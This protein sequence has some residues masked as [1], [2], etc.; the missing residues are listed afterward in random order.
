MN[1][2]NISTAVKC[3]PF[4]PEGSSCAKRSRGIMSCAG[5]SWT[6]CSAAPVPTLLCYTLFPHNTLP[7]LPLDPGL[8]QGNSSFP[9]HPLK[10]WWKGDSAFRGVTPHVNFQLASPLSSQNQQSRSTEQKL[11]YRCDLRSS[12]L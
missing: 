9:T 4:E 10:K 6:S 7:P 3:C 1:K 2:G 8:T 12:V 11:Y 5:T